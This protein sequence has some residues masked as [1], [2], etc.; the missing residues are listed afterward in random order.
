MAKSFPN[1]G[2]TI[3]DTSADLPSASAALEG[4]MMFQKDTN[5]LKIC[6]GSN[7]IIATDTDYPITS[8][9]VLLGTQT[10]SS[11]GNNISFSSVPSGWRHLK[12]VGSAQASSGGT[13]TELYLRFNGDSGNNYSWFRDA[14]EPAFGGSYNFNRSM[15]NNVNTIYGTT[16]SANAPAPFEIIV[17]NYGSTSIQKTTH[18][19]G[20]DWGNF[21]TTYDG[22]GWVSYSNAAGVWKS[23]SAIT[24]VTLTSQGATMI[25]GSSFSLYAF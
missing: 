8:Q 16:M 13:K 6:D 12:I 15:N 2:V 19:R 20:M 18:Q 22:N 17:F 10:L 3:I 24:S 14:I 25:A 4:V 23:T 9:Q 11:A 1:T 21:Q 5:E 7:W